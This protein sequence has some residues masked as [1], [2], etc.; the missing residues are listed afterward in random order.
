MDTLRYPYDHTG[1]GYA[2]KEHSTSHLIKQRVVICTNQGDMTRG[3]SVLDMSIC[4]F[5]IFLL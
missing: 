3:F 4:P 5:K 2:A 1:S